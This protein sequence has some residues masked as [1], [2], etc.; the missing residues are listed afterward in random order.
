VRITF[1][2]ADG[3]F[4]ADENALSCGLGGADVSGVEHYL[5]LQRSSEEKDPS[6]DWGVYVEFD[7]QIN[8]GYGRVLQCRLSRKQLS[9]DLSG[10]LARRVSVQGLDV[11]LA[12]DDA[13]YRQIESGL[14]RIFRGMPHS[15]A[16]A[17]DPGNP[18]WPRP[19]LLAR[20]S[21]SAWR[22]R[23]SRHRERDRQLH[24]IPA[25]EYPPRPLLCRLDR[26]GETL[27]TRRQR[28]RLERHAQ[29]LAIAL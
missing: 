26:N 14:P 24:R 8:S 19:A 18:P 29:T 10:D 21:T 25:Q 13:L 4:V 16:I 5:T 27:D 23:V 6:E 2:A 1:R 22:A 7:D 20:P 17:L 15:L 28:R 12:L 9:L 11:T 3:G